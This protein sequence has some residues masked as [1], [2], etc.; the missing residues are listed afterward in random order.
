VAF[1]QLTHPQTL[2]ARGLAVL[3]VILVAVGTGEGTAA[4]DAL[5]KPVAAT[6]RDRLTAGNKLYR[7]REFDKAIDEYKAGA[8]VEDA[9]VFH[10][11]LGQ[12]YRQLGKHED[13]IWHYE[14][15]LDRARPSGEIKDAVDG[16][17][18]QLKDELATKAKIKA[19]PPTGPA[20][21]TR[22]IER[23]AP[24]TITLVERGEP[25][26]RDSFAWG[27]VGAGA[28]AGGVSIGFLLHGNGLDG[29]ANM[30]TR[31]DVR[32]ELHDQANRARLVG[33]IVGVGGAALLV[34]GIV[35]LVIHPTGSARAIKVARGLAV[36]DRSVH[37]MLRF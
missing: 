7:L 20:P 23:R 35:K 5:A 18:R 13:A 24:E 32:N 21:D 27:L 31:Q 3:A 15:F 6:A 29:D 12:C 4:A 1:R 10:Y 16:F 11:N 26:Y 19:Q 30:E 25:W 37:L 34:T 36:T 33:T 14:R 28:I 9:P 22:P 8:L 2:I 17:V